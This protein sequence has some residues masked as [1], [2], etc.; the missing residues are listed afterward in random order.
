M[1]A[2]ADEL[3][4]QP[5]P[6]RHREELGRL[7]LLGKDPRLF[8]GAA[9]RRVEALECE[10]HDEPDQHGEP[11][12]E[13]TEHAR[14]TVAI[15]EIAAVG[16]ATTHEQHRGDRDGCHADHDYSGPRRFTVRS[17]DDGHVGHTRILHQAYDE[18]AP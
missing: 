15:L 18:L 3:A 17:A 8:L 10:K 13:H 4:R 7:E 14:R 16:S 5:P 12:C 11:G 9:T 1:R 2:V 6:H